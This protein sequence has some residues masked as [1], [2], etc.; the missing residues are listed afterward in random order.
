MTEDAEAGGRIYWVGAG[1]Y[2]CRECQGLVSRGD[3]RRCDR[4]ECPGQPD[5]ED[6]NDDHD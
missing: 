5:E 6:S 1:D 3:L 2:F 4:P